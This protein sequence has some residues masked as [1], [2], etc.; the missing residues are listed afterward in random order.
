MF[1]FLGGPYDGMTIPADLCRRACP[2]TRIVS[3]GRDRV[4]VTLPAPEDWPRVLAGQVDAQDS[5]RSYRYEMAGE[6]FA[7]AI[8]GEVESFQAFEHVAD[9]DRP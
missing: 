3:G 6:P 7:R 4:L 1:R 9:S 8:D 2:P 5:E